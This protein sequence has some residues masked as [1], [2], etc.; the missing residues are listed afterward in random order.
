MPLA[1][2]AIINRVKKACLGGV[3]RPKT[4]PLALDD[5]AAPGDRRLLQLPARR[6]G[7]G[8]ALA[9][10]EAFAWELPRPEEF[11]VFGPRISAPARDTRAPFVEL[12]RE[13]QVDEIAAV[14]IEDVPGDI[15]LVQSLHDDDLGRGRRIGLAGRQRLV[16]GPDRLLALDVALGLLHRVWIVEDLDIAA[17]AQRR[18]AHRG[19]EPEPADGR[20]EVFLR[21]LIL[22]EDHPLAPVALVPGAHDE[23]SGGRGDID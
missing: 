17:T 20:G 18:T 14:R 6:I 8:A 1:N 9:V 19:R 21:T 15:P 2:R 10:F 7:T 4:P 11:A 12:H 23:S 5:V 22:E 13:H 3:V 16:V